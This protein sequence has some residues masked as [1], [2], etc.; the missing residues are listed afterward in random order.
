MGD[1]WTRY[2]R[3]AYRNHVTVNGQARLYAVTV[4][5]HL[6]VFAWTGDHVT[7]TWAPGKLLDTA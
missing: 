6:Q 7:G 4:Q 2:S 5:G 3:A 1:G